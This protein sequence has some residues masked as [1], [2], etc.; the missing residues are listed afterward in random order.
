MKHRHKHIFDPTFRYTPSHDTN[1]RK[2][3]ERERRRLQRE[4]K[5]RNVIPIK[6]E[7]SK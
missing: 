5:E 1:I 6:R 7:A 4:S 3:F 2:T